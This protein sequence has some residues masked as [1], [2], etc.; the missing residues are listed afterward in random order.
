M[1]KFGAAAALALSAAAWCNQEPSVNVNTRYTVESVEVRA[2]EKHRISR[3]LQQDLDSLVGEKLDQGK[4][5]SLTRRIAREL[6]ARRVVQR[7]ARGTRPEHVAVIFE[8]ISKRAN[9]DV[10]V[11]K[12]VYHSKQGWTASG[13]A[14]VTVHDNR[15]GFGI[16]SDG[17]TL[18]ERFAG[19][20]AHYD[21]KR[22]FTD[23]VRLAFDFESFHQQWNRATLEALAANPD[24]PGVYRNRYNF[25]PALSLHP[26]RSLTLEVGASFQR[27]QTQFPAA[28]KEAAN[29]V[30][31][32]LRFRR[33]WEVSEASHVLEAGYNLRA[34]TRTLDSDYVYAR[35]AFTA[36]WRYYQGRQALRAEFQGGLIGGRAPLFER[37]VLGNSSTLRG[38]SKWDLDPLGGRRAAHGSLEYDYSILRVLYDTGSVWDTRRDSRVRHSLGLGLH[39]HT[40][41]RSDSESEREQGFTLAVAF[42]LKEGRAEPIFMIGMNF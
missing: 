16:L 6:D 10:S 9:F 31:S 15:F 35:H 3:A 1:S 38:W 2:R 14:S 19:L 21:R 13:D 37:F 5:D 33:R 27:F 32:T 34:A 41:R 12:F 42:P 20:R 22:I 26:A 24:V 23:R 28:R 40:K 4:L 39:I 36:A 8:A 30:I 25:Q 29:A 7:L 18:L 11:P 17:D